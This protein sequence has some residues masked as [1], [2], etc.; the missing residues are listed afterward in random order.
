[1]KKRCGDEKMKRLLFIDDDL[2]FLESNRIYFQKKGYDIVCADRVSEAFEH[3]R[4]SRLDCIILDIDMPDM[5]GVVFCSR[6][7][8]IS[9]VPVIFLSGFSDL[10]NR[11]AGFRAGGD[12]FLAKPYDFVELELRIE[13][14]TRTAETVFLNQKIKYGKLEIDPDQRTVAYDGRTDDFSALQF[15]IIAFLAKHPGKVFSY[16]QLYESIWKTPI[17]KSRHNLQV[18]VA[19]VRQKLLRLCEGRAYI[20][21]I[22]RKGYYFDPNAEPEPKSPEEPTDTQRH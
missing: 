11:I 1:M 14:R 6:I 18:A 2:D 10:E 16:E 4:S 9:S 13:A 3:I 15:D 19:S 20:R 17:V 8:E 12:D 5:N 22:S 21:T 7:R